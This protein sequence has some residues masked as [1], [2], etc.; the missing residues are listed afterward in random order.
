MNGDG[1]EVGSYQKAVYYDSNVTKGDGENE[2]GNNRFGRNTNQTRVTIKCPLIKIYCMVRMLMMRRKCLLSS[3]G[4]PGLVG[5][6]GRKGK[7]GKR[8]RYTKCNNI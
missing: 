3:R 1:R 8:S 6:S 7:S 2:S 5:I 4:I